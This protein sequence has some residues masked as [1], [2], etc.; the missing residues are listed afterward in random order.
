MLHVDADE[1]YDL[2]E[3]GRILRADPYRIR[4]WARTGGAPLVPRPRGRFALPRAWVDAAGGQSGSDPDALLGYWR[5]RLAPP[6]VH[7]RR[8]VRDLGE[9]RLEPLLDAEEAG[10]RLHADLLRLRRLTA[11]G[12][13]PALR[14]DGVPRYDALLVTRLAEGDEAG[15]AARR[16]EVQEAARFEYATDLAAGATPPAPPPA[17][18]PAEAVAAAPRAWH[19]PDDIASIESMPASADE[20][21]AEAEPPSGDSR[22]IRTEG[23]E[24]VDEDE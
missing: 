8:T 7:A 9:L 3:A 14:I 5:E 6:S 17:P 12:V 4:R 22:L 21:P 2:S 24:T 10:R 11:E 16:E 20:E 13:L 23:F 19:L 15:A 18:A 1:L